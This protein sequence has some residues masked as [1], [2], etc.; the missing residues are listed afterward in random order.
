MNSIDTDI[1][2]YT[3]SELMAILEINEINK[4][5]II[6]KT[7]D[8]IDRYKKKD[9]NLAVFFQE[10]QSQLLQYADGLEVQK[11][12]QLAKF[13]L[14]VTVICLMM[15][16]TLAEISNRQIGYKMKILH[17]PIKIKAIR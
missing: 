6:E 11:H 7:T 1:S 16:R 2:N 15:P 14:R 13:W 4:D 17:R 8:F 9:P 5:E 3:L 12:L 10:I